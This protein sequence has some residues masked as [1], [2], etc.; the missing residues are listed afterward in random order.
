M[1]R[2]RDSCADY[3]S[4]FLTRPLIIWLTLIARSQ[5]DSKSSISSE[6]R[7]TYTSRRV[8][9]ID[10]SYVKRLYN[11]RLACFDDTFSPVTSSANF[12]ASFIESCFAESI[13]LYLS[14][15]NPGKKSWIPAR[16]DAC[17]RY[18]KTFVG[19]LSVRKRFGLRI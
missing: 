1:I 14:Y 15:N 9:A 2:S 7:Y 4:P 6:I 11:S 17:L 18:L 12:Y 3:I 5:I 8:V 19:F 10:W 16:V 13:A